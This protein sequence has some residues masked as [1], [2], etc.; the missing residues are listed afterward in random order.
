MHD[1]GRLKFK[2]GKSNFKRIVS[3]LKE[4]NIDKVQKDLVFMKINSTEMQSTDEY[5]RQKVVEKE[6][7]ESP[8]IT[9]LYP[10][11]MK[12]CFN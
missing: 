12:F 4:M 10:I 5:C 7:C 11:L 1:V 2:R 9:I 3:L 6:M 8:I